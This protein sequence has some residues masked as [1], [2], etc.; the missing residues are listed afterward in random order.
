MAGILVLA[1]P[2]SVSLLAEAGSGPASSG[3]Q[4][5]YR[6]AVSDV[7]VALEQRAAWMRSGGAQVPADGVVAAAFEHVANDSTS[8]LALHTHLVL[9]NLATGTD[10]L[11]GLPGWQRA[12]AV[13]GGA[14]CRLPPG[15][16]L[17]YH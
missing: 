15:P 12:V 5:P 3:L 6:Q 7:V 17:P 16:A 4:E 8:S 9:A 14:W 11:L 2:K 1:A 10:Q 13:A